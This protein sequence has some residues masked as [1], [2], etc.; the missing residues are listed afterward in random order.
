M[1]WL[2]DLGSNV[3]VDRIIQGEKLKEC[4]LLVTSTPHS[5][6]NVEAHF[7]DIL[8][9]NGFTKKH[10]EN[11]V[12]TFLNHRDNVEAVVKFNHGVSHV[13]NSRYMSPMLL[14][15]ISILADDDI[16]Q[17]SRKSVAEC[18]IYWRLVRCI[19][20]KYCTVN[21]RQFDQMHSYRFSKMLA[22]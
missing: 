8:V 21:G 5:S 17:L 22:N 3:N 7:K 20:R 4:C 18:E 1:D 15:F 9:I 13:D 16:V 19:Y 14:Q 12:G 2:D 6:R 10:S 11:F